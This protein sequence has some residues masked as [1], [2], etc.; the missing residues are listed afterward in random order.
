MLTI[1]QVDVKA[2]G[3]VDQ[4]IRLPFRLFDKHPQWVPQI[5]G[6]IQVMLNPE[7]H[8]YYEH[9]TAD[10]FVAKRDG[11]VVGRIGALENRPFNKYHGSKDAEFYLFETEDDQ[12]VASALFNRVFEWSHQRGLNHVVGPKGFSP[13]D[14]YG[15]QIE[16]YDHRCM[17]TMMNYNYPYYIKL[18]E[19]VGFTKAVDFVSC[20]IKR[21]DFIIPEKVRKAA[22]I[23]KK[24]GTFE[25]LKF[26]DKNDLKGWAKA[27]GEAYN[28][29]FVN[30]WEYYP[31]TEKEVKFALDN[32]MTIAD[33]KLMK[34]ILHKGE[35]VGFLFAFPDISAALQRAH[36]HIYDPNNSLAVNPIAIADI[37]IEL[38]RTKWVSF[39]GVG[40]LPEYQG[41]GGNALLYDEMQKTIVNSSF[42]HAELTQMAETATQI[43][44]DII[45]LGSR[46]YKNHRVFQI[47]I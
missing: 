14:G 30:N 13:F 19:A 16:G 3:Q 47:Q 7:K 20:Y 4:F 34:A 15:L 31:L 39:N 10:F 32:I 36:G 8:P 12:E 43:R 35:I 22:D 1:E 5:I 27:V 41:L 44:K 26:K 37:M 21:D 24:R 2:K 29:T 6:D 42:E 28:R 46:P 17:M 25:V 33:P 9:S 11:K 40:V 18:V 23:V 45:T 38:K